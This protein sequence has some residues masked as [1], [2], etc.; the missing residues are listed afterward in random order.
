MWSKFK[1]KFLDFNI[2][3]YIIAITEIDLKDT[4]ILYNQIFQIFLE[5]FD[6]VN[7]FSI[8]VANILFKH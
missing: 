3:A 7:V 8:D 5:Y 6:I 2:M 4:K 1:T